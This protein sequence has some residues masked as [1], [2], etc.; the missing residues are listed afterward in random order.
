MNFIDIEPDIDEIPPGDNVLVTIIEARV[1]ESNNGNPGIGLTLEDEQ[2]RELEDA[3]WVTRNTRDRVEELVT[4]CG[5]P[6]PKG[7]LKLNVKELEGRRVLVDLVEQEYRGRTSTRV[8]TWSRYGGSDVPADTEGL[9][10]SDKSSGSFA[11]AA[12]E[13][14]S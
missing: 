11:D 2:Q 3:V 8:T 1:I 13:G 12:D 6:F 5:L 10:S 9:W 4:A 14:A 7:Q